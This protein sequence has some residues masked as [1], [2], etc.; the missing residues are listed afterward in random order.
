MPKSL[1]ILCW[2]HVGHQGRT[3][4]HAAIMLKGAV[5]SR[6]QQENSSART[7]IS[8]WPDSGGN[9][10]SV[11]KG[12]PSSLFSD[13]R[14]EIGSRTQEG[15]HTR[16]FQP[17]A[18]QRSLLNDDAIQLHDGPL[19]VFKSQTQEL[20]DAFY[21]LLTQEEDGSSMQKQY[22]QFPTDNIPIWVETCLLYTSDA[23]DEV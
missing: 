5:E 1:D 7:Y 12:S 13:V 22:A 3:N 14:K 20:Q 4:G 19:D 8:W 21:N 18:G 17:R 23:A 9:P 6:D 16:R 2:T 10:F 15:L 11:R